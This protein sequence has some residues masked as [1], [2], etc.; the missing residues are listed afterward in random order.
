[1]TTAR[2]LGIGLFMPSIATE[3]KLGEHDAVTKSA[4]DGRETSLMSIERRTS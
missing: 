2:G 1:M 3:H 4:I